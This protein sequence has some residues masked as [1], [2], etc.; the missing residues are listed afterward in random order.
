MGVVLT[1]LPTFDEDD[2]RVE[3]RFERLRAWRLE[4]SRRS[5]LSPAYV[6][7]NETLRL[8]AST[9]VT[10]LDDLSRIKGIGS[11]KLERY[12]E[13]LLALLQDDAD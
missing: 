12:G 8:L 5:N 9:H 2:P 7:P 1:G 3:E 4:E 13:A 6:F 10:S 11:S